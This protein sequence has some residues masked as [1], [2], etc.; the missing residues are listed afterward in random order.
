[1]SSNLSETDPVRDVSQESVIKPISSVLDEPLV[2][3]DAKSVKDIKEEPVKEETVKEETVTISLKLGDIIEFVAPN[4]EILNAHIFMIEYIDNIKIKLVDA[5]SFQ[6]TQLVIKDGQIADQTIMEIILLSRNEQE[7]Y[8]RQND[9]LTGAWI[10]IYFGGDIPTIITGLITDLENDMIEIQTVDKETIYI[11]FGYQGIPEDIPIET[12]EIRPPPA[13]ET[14]G[15]EVLGEEV[16]GEE[17]KEDL[18]DLEGLKEE[19]GLVE[20]VYIPEQ[21][22]RQKIS[23]LIIDADQ[24]EFGDIIKVHEI[25]NIEREKYRYNIDAQKKRLVRRNDI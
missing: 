14:E 25:I 23:R 13:S 4:N 1:M 3:G 11:D 22:I 19:K 17:G 21:Q 8:A 7:G 9:L 24:I 2:E 12:F 5:D 15:E 6:K 16:L 10:N 18:E 20:P